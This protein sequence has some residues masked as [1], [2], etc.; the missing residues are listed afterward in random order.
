MRI[1]NKLFHK[2]KQHHEINITKNNNVIYDKRE[3]T[4]FRFCKN[5]NCGSCKIYSK[6]NTGDDIRFS[7]Y[8]KKWEYELIKEQYPELVL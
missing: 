1:R 8:L 3:E 4:V 6:C 2:F 5:L 7:P